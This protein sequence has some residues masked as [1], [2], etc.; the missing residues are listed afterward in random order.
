MSLKGKPRGLEVGLNI[1]DLAF[2]GVQD[3][4]QCPERAHVLVQA[5]LVGD[6]RLEE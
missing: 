6:G 3:T 1:S 4:A 2:A 5:G